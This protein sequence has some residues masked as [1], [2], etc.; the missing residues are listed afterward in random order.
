MHK[1]TTAPGP[2]TFAGVSLDLE[3]VVCVHLQ[4]LNDELGVGAVHVKHRHW[5][6]LFVVHNGI[7]D[8]LPISER[9]IWLVPG[10]LDAGR[11][12]ANGGEVARCS[13][14][15]C[16]KGGEKKQKKK[17]QG[18]SG[19]QGGCRDVGGRMMLMV[20]LLLRDWRRGPPA[21]PSK[22]L[23]LPASHISYRAS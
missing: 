19:S 12:H 3:D 9:A 22:H 2:S 18:S 21:A 13:S 10:E 7:Q 4:T 5:I 8:N 23:V 17:K 1:E 11:T 6:R 20:L 14:G 15:N 16:G